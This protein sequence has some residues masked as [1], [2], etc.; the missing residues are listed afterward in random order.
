M[1]AERRFRIGRCGQVHSLLDSYMQTARCGRS[2][3]N[4]EETVGEVTGL[5]CLGGHHRI[6]PQHP[7]G[8]LAQAPPGSVS[9]Q[10]VDAALSQL[11]EANEE[12][13]DAW[14][15]GN[16]SAWRSCDLRVIPRTVYPAPSRAACDLVVLLQRH[17]EGK[18]RF[19]V[20][21]STVTA[22]A[23]LLRLQGYLLP[24]NASMRAS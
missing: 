19:K 20:L 21:A 22:H 14:I 3:V 2:L 12:A 10:V 6:R 13:H 8:V 9:L 1:T 4:G 7:A 5:H 23:E 15:A 17:Y 24:G 18:A 11:E 16:P